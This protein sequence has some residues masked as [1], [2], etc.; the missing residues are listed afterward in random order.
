MI[1]SRFIEKLLNGRKVEWRA[2]G[3]VSDF[4]NGFAFKSSLF[5]DDGQTIVRITNINGKEVDL[6]DVK[7]FSLDDYSTI[8][9]SYEIKK[10]DI[11]IAMSGATTGKIGLYNYEYTSYL[12]QRVGK[13][14]P[15]K[16]ILNNRYLYH[17]L[18]SKANEI[19]I[20]AGGGAQPNLSSNKLMTE[21]KIPIP[22]LSVQ[23]EIA[24]VLDAFTSLTAE[25]TAELTSR[26]KQYQY[27]KEHLLNINNNIVWKSLSEITITTK[28]IKWENNKKNYRYIDL[29]SVNREN[30]RITE[31][32]EINA[33]NAPSRAQK[34]IEKND[35]LF[36]TTRPTQQRMTIVPEE[37]DSQIASTGYCV[38]R[39][40]KEE[41]LPE[42]IYYNISTIDFKNYV[43]EYQ[44]GSAYPAISDYK[45]KEYKI[46]IPSIQMQEKLISILNRF[47]EL[48]HSIEAGLPS[49]IQL[50]KQQYEY[51]RN[52]LLNFK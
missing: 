30:N 34:I 35:I 36:A 24:R 46:P 10:G 32:I 9:T 13:F 7:Y 45:V 17:Y 16:N 42:W 39:P 20:I 1:E 26:Q 6:S 38:L 49:E 41:V 50:R 23:T 12:N 18:L 3:D 4:Q 15:K 21:I 44:S 29:T 31:T 2:L 11:L 27:F 48:T 25:L 37:Y 43:E 22:P 14:I 33:K 5:K 51:Y 19:Y 8:L 40:N 47:E 28:N 52:M